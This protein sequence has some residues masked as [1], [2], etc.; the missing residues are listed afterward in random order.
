MS[1]LTASAE[2]TTATDDTAIRPFRIDVPQRDLDELRRRVQ[3]TKWPDRETDPSQGVRLDTI[4]ALAEYWATDYDWRKF[5]QRFSELPH[6]MTKIDGVDIHFIHVRSKHEDALP[7]IVTHGWPGSTVEQ[8]KIIGPLTDPTA[9]GASASDAFHLVIPSLP[10]HGF[11]GKP[12]ETGWDPIRIARAWVI[13]MQRLGYEKLRRA[14]RRL[15][16]RGHRADGPAE[17][18][19][20]ARAS[21]RT[22]PPPSRRTSRRR[23][24]EA[25]RSQRPSQPTN[26]RRTTSSTTS[27]RPASGTPMRWRTARRRCMASRTR[28]SAWRPG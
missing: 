19:G 2:P 25:A 24:P 20:I 22:C 17:A 3:A 15:G 23:S 7:L 16:E 1:T 27:S 6:F 5:E 4:Q 10:G 26:R 8:L 28:R 9:R 14:G 13:L 18:C 21:T 12:R 11:S